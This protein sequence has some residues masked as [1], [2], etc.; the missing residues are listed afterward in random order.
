M[1]WSLSRGLAWHKHII[2]TVP[3]KFQDEQYRVQNLARHREALQEY[4]AVVAEYGH[5]GD[6]KKSKTDSPLPVM[7]QLRKMAF[8]AASNRLCRL[9]NF[10]TIRVGKGNTRVETINGWRDKDLTTTD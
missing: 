7:P 8:A 10:F 2:K 3:I 5:K 1:L 6:D 4:A 9:N